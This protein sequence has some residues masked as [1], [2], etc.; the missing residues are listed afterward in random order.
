[1]KMTSR[2][3]LGLVGAAL[4][5]LGIL[6]GCNKEPKLDTE[7]QK[8]GYA[9]GVQIGNNL[10]RQDIKLDVSAVAAGIKDILE[11][12][13]Q[14]MK[15]DEIKAAMASL[16]QAAMKKMEEEH[17]K[18][19]VDGEKNIKIGADFLE[20]NKAKPGVKVTE[21]GLQYEVI[22]TGTGKK[23]K[24][25][26]TVTAHYAG[27]LIDGTEFDS[28]IKRGEPAD[29]PVNGVIKGWT[30]ALKMM[31]VGSKWKLT[32]PSD[33]AYG[34]EGRPPVIPP[35]AVLVFDIELIGIK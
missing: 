24:D 3:S 9:I 29:F 12:K 19:Q 13:P 6:P 14:R 4:L 28:S 33:L 32:I 35:N 17:K 10:K 22:T 2:Q 7:P 15:E 11:G 27:T 1:M 16:Q 21:S 26:D 34:A 5:G 31:T 18:M 25:K 20:K 23:P 30:E 8:T